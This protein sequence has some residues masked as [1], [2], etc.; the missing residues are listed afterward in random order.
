MK[1]KIKVIKEIKENHRET[2]KSYK[3][4]GVIKYVEVLPA[5]NACKV[6]KKWKGKKILL[7]VAIREQSL[8]IKSC[9]NK[10]YGYCRCCY[11]PVIE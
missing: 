11:I 6:C 8:P 7:E 2:L 10:T 5:E 4:S 3:E 9:C 1:E